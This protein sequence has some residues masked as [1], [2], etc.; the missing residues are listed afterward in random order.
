MIGMIVSGR[1]FKAFDRRSEGR[2]QPPQEPPAGPASPQPA[3]APSSRVLD[4]TP[5]VSE[6]TVAAIAAAVYLGEHGLSA[7]K[8]GSLRAASGDAWSRAGRQRIMND[9]LTVFQRAGRSQS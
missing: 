6:E 1:I 7:E 4:G 5:L 9:R 3:A 2:R 8:G